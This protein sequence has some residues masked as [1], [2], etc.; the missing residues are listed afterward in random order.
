MESLSTKTALESPWKKPS[1]VLLTA[2]TTAKLQGLE[3]WVH[4]SPLKR[5]PPDSWNHTPAADL[6]LKLTREV[7]TQKQ[8]DFLAK[9]VSDN[10]TALGYFLA[11]KGGACATANT[12]HNT[13]I[14]TS[15][16]AAN[17]IN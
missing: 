3:P 11:E 5:A 6:K 17:M 14:N 2:D 4:I 7:P 16:V 10:R 9:M 8:M 1:Q 15:G 12:S 13:W